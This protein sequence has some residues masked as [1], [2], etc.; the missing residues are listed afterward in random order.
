MQFIGVGL[1]F[2]LFVAG[3]RAEPLA[4]QPYAVAYDGRLAAPVLINGAGPFELLIDTG[5]SQ[6]I[7]FAGAAAVLGL[8]P[9]AGPPT[10]VHTIADKVSSPTYELEDLALGTEHVQALRVAVLPSPNPSGAGPAGVLG[11]DVLARYALVFDRPSGRMM[12][13]PRGLGIPAP[14]DRWPSTA[15]YPRRLK[16]LPIDLWFIDARY[17]GERAK[18]L[19]DLGTGVT[20]MTWALA[21]RLIPPRD[22]PSRSDDEVHDALGKGLPAFRLEGLPIEIAGRS[23]RKQIALVADVPVFDYLDF[24]DEP[25][26]IIGAS[27]LKDASFAIDFENQRLYV[28][29]RS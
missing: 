24:G 10:L 19:F 18:T 5:S 12:L 11:I 25:A 17:V 1:A 27:L 23:W 7:L 3:V 22:M 28:A 15:L 21:R 2:L 16:D 13:Y 20:I 8:E 26:G 14:Y 29:P 9:L 4:V 6:T